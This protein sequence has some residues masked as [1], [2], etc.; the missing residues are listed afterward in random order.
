MR[1]FSKSDY[2]DQYQYLGQTDMVQNSEFQLR[3]VLLGIP[4]FAAY[5][6]YDLVFPMVWFFLYSLC[7]GVLQ[8]ITHQARKRYRRK[9]FQ[10]AVICNTITAVIFISLPIFLW[11]TGDYVYR[12]AAVA[13]SFG[14]MMHSV[15]QRAALPSFA[16]GDGFANGLF[17]VLVTIDI[18]L[19][20]L[21]W[22]DKLIIVTLGI[23]IMS[24]Y[25][26]ALSAA[27]RVRAQLRLA[28]NRTAEIQKMQLVGQMAGGIAHDFNNILTVIMGNLDL[29]KEVQS[30]EEKLS[31]VDGAYESAKK[32]SVLISHLLS[33]SRQAH[34]SPKLVDLRDFVPTF[35]KMIRPIISDKV[36]IKVDISGKLD[37]INVDIGQFETAILN[38]V[39]NARD[40]IPE[41]GSITIA[42]K[43]VEIKSTDKQARERSLEDGDYVAI[44][45]SDSGSG[46]DQA[47]QKRIFEPFFTTK[48]VGQGSG[49]GLSMAKGFA[50]QSYGGLY[51][52]ID[53]ERRTR[54]TFLLPSAG[55]ATD[56]K[57][58]A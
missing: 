8:F 7:L 53:D 9:I 4:I 13:L 14:A 19:G 58:A 23:A 36:V 12:V 45:I 3:M 49:L 27:F 35:V 56:L 28:T 48:D 41:K 47:L 54:F 37:L 25:C 39:I 1:W 30:N 2:R 40:A 15:S 22:P 11:M 18:L 20:V 43:M 5:F 57:S 21:S 32:A 46:I 33:F 44:S 50:E 24:Y 10:T 38:L 6:A 34:L 17:I 16:I 29:Y 26:I 31:L 42:A 52:D 55:K 51:L